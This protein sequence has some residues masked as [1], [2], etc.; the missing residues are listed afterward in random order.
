MSNPVARRIAH[1]KRSG[2]GGVLSVC[3]AHPEVI[4]AAVDI[5]GEYD[6]ILLLESTSNQVDQFGGYTGK[7][8]AQ[9]IG[10]TRASVA[11]MGFPA[12]RLVFGGDHLGPNAWQHLPAE[13]AMENA[14][15]LVRQ[16]AAA[17]YEKIHLDCSMSCADD[18]VPLDDRTVAERAARLCEIAEKACARK[19]KG[20]AAVYIIGTEVP[21]PG[22]AREDLE[23]SIA[24]TTPAAARNT[25]EIHRRI[26]ADAGLG[27][28][29]PRIVGLVVQPGVEFDHHKIVAYRPQRARSLSALADKFEHAVFEA[30]STDYQPESAFKDLVNDHFAILKVGPALTFAYREAVFAL[31]DAAHAF[32]GDAVA[33]DVRAEAE[34]AML[35]QPEKW[36]NYYP[37]TAAQQKILR[38]YSLSDRIRYYWPD[39]ALEEAVRRLRE[40]ID[41]RPL[42]FGLL[43]QYLSAAV[44]A[45]H[46]NREPLNSDNLIRHHIR[47]ALRP[48]LEAVHPG[49]G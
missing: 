8:P 37:G 2:K 33:V 36:R 43:H 40:Q 21:V 11:K 26:F 5:V 9:F 19:R 20:S 32:H 17:G 25:Y 48:Y 34:K 4:R 45:C 15:E 6:E 1:H 39:S 13:Q 35:A 41:A 38:A 44:D 22:G 14:C 12:E 47:F 28:V 49:T 18:P 31:S 3:S 27:A 42:P 29:W 24:P 16:Y 7:T 23:D 46:G 30:H 10:E